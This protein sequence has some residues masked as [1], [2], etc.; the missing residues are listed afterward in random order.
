MVIVRYFSN[1][2]LTK[3][4]LTVGQMKF[5]LIER[6]FGGKPK[7]PEGI[8]NFVP[9]RNSKGEQVIK[10]FSDVLPLNLGFQLHVGNSTK[11]LNG[12]FAIGD[13]TEGDKDWVSNSRLNFDVLHSLLTTGRYG[14]KVEIINRGNSNV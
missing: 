1:D 4:V 5:D 11:D 6:N 14:S 7:I 9:G 3:S 8:Y 12:C 10:I 2:K 13:A